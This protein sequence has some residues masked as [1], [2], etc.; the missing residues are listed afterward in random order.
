MFDK[1]N[2]DY[3]VYYN[4]SYNRL[5]NI[6]R[7][8]INPGFLS[9]LIFRIADYIYKKNPKYFYFMTKILMLIP[10]IFFGIE[11]E[12][13]AEIG[14]GF[15]IVHGH[16]IVIGNRVIIEENVSIYQGVTLGGNGKKEKIIK[17]KNMKQPYIERDVVLSPGAKIL[18]PVCIGKKSLIGSNIVIIKDIPIET[19][20]I[21]EN[22]LI[23]RSR[24]LNENKIEI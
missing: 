24:K 10:R 23:M 3:Y 14:A 20:V 13:G 2:K 22:K 19:T 9:I 11:I 12:I 17:N 7:I 16:G 1:I 5:I 18:G 6:L 4:H 15:Y 8:I 21:Q